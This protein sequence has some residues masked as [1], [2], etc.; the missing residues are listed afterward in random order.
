MA[1]DEKSLSPSIPS[2]LDD[3]ENNAAGMPQTED[4]QDK[5]QREFTAARVNE[6]AADPNIVDWDGPDDPANPMNWS[7]RRK[8]TTVTVVSSISW[9]V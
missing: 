7:E 3:V 9:V 5:V 2:A 4:V 1:D 8:W 6:P